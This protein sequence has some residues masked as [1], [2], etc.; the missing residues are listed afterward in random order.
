[1]KTPTQYKNQLTELGLDQIK[2][3][4]VTHPEAQ[5]VLT[6]LAEIHSHLKDLETS[7]NLDIHALRSQY[8]GRIAALSINTHHKA[9]V[10]EEQRAE[11]E[12]DTKLAPYEE[13]KSQ[14]Q[15]LLVTL[16]E[17]RAALEKVAPGG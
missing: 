14:L 7:L 8:Q 10:E 16:E 13:V 4:G 6:R 17:K 9:K 15:A 1:M 11:E 12:R 5:K 3:D 2:I